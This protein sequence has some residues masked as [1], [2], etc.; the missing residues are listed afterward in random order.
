VE[1]LRGAAMPW[2]D[3]V[4]SAGAFASALGIRILDEDGS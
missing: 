2:G 4:A 1:R 3:V